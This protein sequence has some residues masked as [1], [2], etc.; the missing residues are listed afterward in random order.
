MHLLIILYL[1]VQAPKELSR[2]HGIKIAPV[3]NCSIDEC[4]L[5]VG[6]AVEYDGIMSASCMNSAVVIFLDSIEKVNSVVQNGVVYRT[7]S[8]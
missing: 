6:K 7:N 3:V 8:L 2:R 5:A 4:S 1:G